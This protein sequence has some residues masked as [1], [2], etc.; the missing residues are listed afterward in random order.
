MWHLLPWQLWYVAT[1]QLSSLVPC[2][3]WHICVCLWQ[4]VSFVHCVAM[5]TPLPTPVV[6]TT[7]ACGVPTRSTVEGPWCSRM[8]PSSTASSTATCSSPAHT[9]PRRCRPTTGPS[10]SGLRLHSPHSLVGEDHCSQ[11]CLIVFTSDPKHLVMTAAYLC[12]YVCHCRTHTHVRTYIRTFCVRN[13]CGSSQ[14]PK[15][16]S[17]K[18]F[19]NYGMY[20]KYVCM[21]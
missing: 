3:F 15:Y 11:L 12:T 4:P 9:T 16:F 5:A 17:N 8:A 1:Q 10:H 13:F 21:C 20:C 2:C 6:H 14:P 18:N 19:P 7:L